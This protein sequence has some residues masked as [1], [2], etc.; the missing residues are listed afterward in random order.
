[1]HPRSI[2][3]KE[4]FILFFFRN[5]YYFVTQ[6]LH[7]KIARFRTL[8]CFFSRAKSLYIITRSLVKALFFS[9]LFLKK[10]NQ[11]LVSDSVRPNNYT[12]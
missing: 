9:F 5:K 6:F 10:K 4:V 11:I 7:R 1:M 12:K 2:T 8:V 3:G